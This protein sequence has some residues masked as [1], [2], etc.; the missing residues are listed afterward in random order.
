M[1]FLNL[2]RVQDEDCK[3]RTGSNKVSFKLPDEVA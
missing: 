3:E 2:L 1:K